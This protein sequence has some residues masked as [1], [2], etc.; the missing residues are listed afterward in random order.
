MYV[1]Y[2]WYVVHDI[3][4]HSHHSPLTKL[5]TTHL[6]HQPLSNQNA[7]QFTFWCESSAMIAL[8]LGTCIPMLQLIIGLGEEQE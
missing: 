1:M 6:I 8:S 2:V 3:S 7:D 4:N 5:T